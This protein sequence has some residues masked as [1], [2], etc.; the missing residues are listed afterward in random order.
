MQRAAYGTCRCGYQRGLHETGHARLEADPL[1]FP[2]SRRDRLFS[3][4][5][6]HLRFLSQGRS[7]RA[8]AF[9]IPVNGTGAAACHAPRRGPML[10]YPGRTTVRPIAA[11][12]RK[13]FARVM[14]REPSLSQPQGRLFLAKDPGRRDTRT[15]SRPHFP[16]PCPPGHIQPTRLRW[17]AGRGAW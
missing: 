16:R 1:A 5:P 4:G 8:H 13:V 11:L 7:R 15:K 9:Q 17:R 14:R 3:A 2:R 10:P 6:V 12:H